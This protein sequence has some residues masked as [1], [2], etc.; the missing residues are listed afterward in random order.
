MRSIEL[1][2]GAGGLAL[3]LARAG[4][5]HELLLEWNHDACD[6]L[7]ANKRRRIKFLR[8]WNIV[9]GDVRQFDFAPYRDVEL[10]A[11]GVPCQP[12]SLGG[13]HR[14]HKDDRDMFPEFVR[15]VST[16][17]PKAFI[18]ENVKGLLRRTFADYFEYVLLYLSHPAITRRPNQSWRDHRA[19]LECLHT[20]GCTTPVDYNVVFQLLNAADYGVPQRR[21]RVFIVGVRSDLK[22]Q[23][24]FP[25]P[26]HSQDALLRQEWLTGEYWERHGVAR[27]RRPEIDARL[28]TRIERLRSE[29][30]FADELLPWRTVRDAI[31]DLPAL[32]PG[33]TDKDDPNHFQN[34]GARSYAG[35]TGSPLDEPAKTLKAGDHGVPGG[36]NTLALS[37]GEVRYFTVRECARLQ[38]FPDE[39]RVVGSWTES[40]RQLGNAVPVQLANVVAQRLLGCLNP[41]VPRAT[42]K[43]AS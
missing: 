34:P 31:S 18:I 43:A 25:E 4:C 40:M 42:R 6:T 2:S 28:E 16:I 9:E 5:E 23:F 37:N 36:E 22:A 11:G 14:G 41:S 3:G 32:R 19:E 29:T 10:L 27:K 21:E 26:T 24:S 1:F 33:M 38:T 7:R 12:F 17:R 35:H 39:F 20:A 8:D 15:A 13:K 30:L